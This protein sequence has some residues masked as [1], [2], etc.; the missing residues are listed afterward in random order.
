MF[1]NTASEILT[2]L[3]QALMI[4]IVGWIVVFAWQ[5]IGGVENFKRILFRK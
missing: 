1:S 2:I 5:D 3:I 4:T